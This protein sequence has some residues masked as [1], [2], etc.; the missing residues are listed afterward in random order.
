[1]LRLSI[2]ASHKK[3]M[4]LDRTTLSELLD[5]INS[6][7][8]EVLSIDAHSTIAQAMKQLADHSMLSA[9]VVVYQEASKDKDQQT[10]NAKLE[11]NFPNCSYTP[12]GFVD[13]R[14]LLGVYI[15]NAMQE[16]SK[17]GQICDLAHMDEPLYRAATRVGNMK[18]VNALGGDGG[19]LRV[20]KK[21]GELDL[22]IREVVQNSFLSML[23]DVVYHRLAITDHKGR[24]QHVLSQSDIV[25]FLYKHPECI[26]DVVHSTVAIEDFGTRDVFVILESSPT[27]IAFATLHKNKRSAAGVVSA[28]NKLIGCLSTSDLRG[29]TPIQ[30]SQL[31]ITVG[32]FLHYRGRKEA[33]RHI[34]LTYGAGGAHPAPY[35]SKSKLSL[36]HKG[37]RA[38]IKEGEAAAANGLTPVTEDEGGAGATSPTTT[39]PPSTSRGSRPS[40]RSDVEQGFCR[41]PVCCQASNTVL[42]VLKALVEYKVHRVYVL[43]EELQPLRVITLTDVLRMVTKVPVKVAASKS[44]SK[45]SSKSRSRAQV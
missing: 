16:L 29:L 7:Q 3:M 37:K 45:S 26:G 8:G 36:F 9:P 38:S 12:I 23:G 34:P 35:K 31:S 22:T 2:Q 32:E 42:E 14:G 28:E 40:R 39:S 41:A 33:L 6:L 13:V 11:I 30:F 15:T 21:T 20:K 17:A 5:D 10:S 19:M 18:V 24:L 4:N 25:S 44:S 27:I 43:D 1:M